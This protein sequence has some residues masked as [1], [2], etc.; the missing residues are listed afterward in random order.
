MKFLLETVFS[1]LDISTS[2]IYS[3]LGRELDANDER[4]INYLFSLNQQSSNSLKSVQYAIEIISSLNRGTL[5]FSSL[6]SSPTDPNGCSIEILFGH[7]E[8]QRLVIGHERRQSEYPAT[9][10]NQPAFFGHKR[11][12]WVR[13][14][15]EPG[16]EHTQ[17][18]DGR[19]D[20]NNHG[21]T[22]EINACTQLENVY[23]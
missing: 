6:S 15:C 19:N 8:R 21:K 13:L 16:V 9:M 11:T 23:K 22:V 4:L 5:R 12:A 14:R 18:T 7:F 20:Y 10:H 17:A 2:F 1:V 3:L